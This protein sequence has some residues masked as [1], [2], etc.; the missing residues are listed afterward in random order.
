MVSVL[1]HHPRH[2]VPRY[3][4]LAAQP[5]DGGRLVVVTGVLVAATSKP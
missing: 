1:P 4:L 5:Y 3:L 2:C